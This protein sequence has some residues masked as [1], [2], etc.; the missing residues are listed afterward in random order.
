[1]A[2]TVHIAFE[3]PA[4]ILPTNQEQ[5]QADTLQTLSWQTLA[6]QH[7]GPAK[8]VLHT[9]GKNDSFSLQAAPSI[10]GGRGFGA[11]PNLPLSNCLRTQHG[12]GEAS[13]SS[14]GCSQLSMKPHQ[15]MARD[16][17]SPVP[18]SMVSLLCSCLPHLLCCFFLQP[19]HPLPFEA[20]AS[21][22]KQEQ[23]VQNMARSQ[24]CIALR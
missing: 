24:H 6:P 19:P 21:F 16:I 18:K 4:C 20:S 2:K 5:Q 8:L 15:V 1:M 14:P 10:K 9:L 17:A 13:R 7:A 22:C 12:R 11:R 23:S 3:L